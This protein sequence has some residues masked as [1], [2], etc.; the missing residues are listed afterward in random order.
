MTYNDEGGHSWSGDSSQDSPSSG[1]EDG[2]GGPLI[3]NLGGYQ[4]TGGHSWTGAARLGISVDGQAQAADATALSGKARII[5]GG[6]LESETTVSGSFR[7]AG[8]PPKGVATG[9]DVAGKNID[10][11]FVPSI[12]GLNLVKN[13]LGLQADIGLFQYG[14]VVGKVFDYTGN[15]LSKEIVRG[16]GAS[17]ST[18]DDGSYELTA[19]GGVNVT[20]Y[21]LQGT[22]SDTFQ[23]PAGGTVTQDF[24]YPSLVVK[25]VDSDYNA[26]EGAPVQVLGQTF[27]T[28]AGGEVQLN[29][30]PVTTHTVRVQDYWEGDITLK[31]QDTQYRMTLGPDSTDFTD[32][33]GKTPYEQG[34]GGV[35]I[36]AVDAETG[37]VVKGMGVTEQNTGKLTRSGPNG[38]AK[39]LTSQVGS[40][41]EFYVATGDKRYRPET[42]RGTI[43]KDDMLQFDVELERKTQVVNT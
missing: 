38:K 26:V 41:V 30:M 31:K 17:D 28:D 9:K 27:E 19:P 1:V 25:V 22:Y 16:S 14:S 12:A 37:K 2:E 7:V 6:N 35:E 39:F 34:T 13:D 20:L 33:D 10:F 5:I 4:D 3:E 40:D 24:T 23:P 42:V 18:N 36:R 15:P 43:P 11:Q 8:D 32:P 21:S 29:E